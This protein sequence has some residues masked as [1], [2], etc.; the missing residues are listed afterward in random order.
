MRWHISGG[1]IRVMDRQSCLVRRGSSAAPGGTRATPPER[2]GQI[3]RCRT[4]P[5]AAMGVPRPV[6]A[7]AGG[8]GPGAPIDVQPHSGKD[9]KTLAEREGHR[10]SFRRARHA[11][12][13]L[14]VTPNG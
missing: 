4:S 10:A 11:C 14:S 3:H 8:D 5:C 12:P 13:S 1:S 2:S 7:A 9:S 6:L